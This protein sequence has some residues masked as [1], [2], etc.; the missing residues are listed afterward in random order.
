MPNSDVEKDMEEGGRVLVKTIKTVFRGLMGEIDAD[1]L[2]GKPKEE[3]KPARLK[4]V[5]SQV[6]SNEGKAEL[7]PTY[8]VCGS[9][10]MRVKVLD[11][12]SDPCPSCG[13]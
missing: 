6:Q 10:K 12:T 11:P 4:V 1:E 9:C 8:I 13:E 7:V 2:V 5:K 3:P